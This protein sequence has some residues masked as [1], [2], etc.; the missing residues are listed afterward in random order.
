MT[1]ETVPLASLTLPLSTGMDFERVNRLVPHLDDLPPIEVDARVWWSTEATGPGPTG[2]RAGRRSGSGV[3]L[4]AR[5]PR[6]AGR[7]KWLGKA[8]GW[9]SWQW[10]GGE[11]GGGARMAGDPVEVVRLIRALSVAGGRARFVDLSDPIGP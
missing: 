4:R 2:W 11:Q 9:I 10:R 8:P 3:T 7:V 5:P 1:D 6:Q